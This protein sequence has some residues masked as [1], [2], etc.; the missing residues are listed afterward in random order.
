[1][2]NWCYPAVFWRKNVGV[3]MPMSLLFCFHGSSH[4]KEVFDSILVFFWVRLQKK[5]IKSL[6]H[7]TISFSIHS[8]HVFYLL[9][10]MPIINNE[11]SLLLGMYHL[12]ISFCP[13]KTWVVQVAFILLLLH[14]QGHNQIISIGRDQACAIDSQMKATWFLPRVV[15]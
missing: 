11:G 9:V 3:E 2:R 12:K 1:M 15:T 4:V 14:I 5:I 6:S 7:S 10:K 8:T 13:V